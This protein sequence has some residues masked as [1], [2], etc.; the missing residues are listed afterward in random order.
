MSDSLMIRSFALK[1]Q[2]ILLGKNHSFHHVFDSFSLLFPSVC[3]RANRSSLRGS[4]L[5]S[6]RSNFFLLLFTKERP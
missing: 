1:T 6:D 4:F 3:P 2:A 5:K